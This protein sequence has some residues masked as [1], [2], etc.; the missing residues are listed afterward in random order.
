MTKTWQEIEASAKQTDV[1]VVRISKRPGRAIT[2]RSTALIKSMF[3][4]FWTGDLEDHDA[5]E[6]ERAI[7]DV[8]VRLLSKMEGAPER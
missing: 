3:V 5:D 6:L 2:I 1:E 7:A 8:A 4:E